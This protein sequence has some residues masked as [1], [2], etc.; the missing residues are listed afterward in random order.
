MAITQVWEQWIKTMKIAARIWKI[1]TKNKV[2]RD[3]QNILPKITSS[4]LKKGQETLHS[5]DQ[6]QDMS[7]QLLKRKEFKSNRIKIKWKSMMKK[8]TM[9]RNRWKAWKEWE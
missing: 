2:H 1:D 6:D 5:R 4:A 3:L 8:K 7:N 9:V